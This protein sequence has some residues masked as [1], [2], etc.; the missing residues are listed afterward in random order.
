MKSKCQNEQSTGQHSVS[1]KTHSSS[2]IDIKRPDPL[3][4][5]P[6]GHDLSTLKVKGQSDT[7]CDQCFGP[8]SEKTCPFHG[9]QTPG[10]V[11]VSLF[12]FICLT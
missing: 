5:K 8:I 2:G 3:T 6:Q 9:H 4:L 7:T 11:F 1:I 10:F 12:K